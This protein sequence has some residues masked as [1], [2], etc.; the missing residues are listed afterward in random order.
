MFIFTKVFLIFMFYQGVS[1]GQVPVHIV[2]RREVLHPRRDLFN[3]MMMAP[4]LSSL[5]DLIHI[6]L[7]T[8]IIIVFAVFITITITIT[9]IIIIFITDLNCDVSHLSLT[10]NPAIS[11]FSLAVLT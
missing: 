11:T 4:V 8:T 9:K 1:G 5:Q 7:F 3:M 2:V 10:E 6:L